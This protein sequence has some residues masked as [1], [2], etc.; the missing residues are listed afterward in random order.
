MG[1]G[2]DSARWQRI[3][4]SGQPIAV[5]ASGSQ[6]SAPGFWLP[7]VPLSHCHTV[8]LSASGYRLQVVAFPPTGI[9][10]QMGYYRHVRRSFAALRMTVGGGKADV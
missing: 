4:V 7:A 6:L 2:R 10:R 5:S 1:A 8:L 3:A 9:Y